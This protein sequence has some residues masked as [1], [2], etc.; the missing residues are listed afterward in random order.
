MTCNECSKAKG[1]IIKMCEIFNGPC[2]DKYANIDVCKEREC[3]YFEQ[4]DRDK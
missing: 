2:Y 3:K 4:I 1:T